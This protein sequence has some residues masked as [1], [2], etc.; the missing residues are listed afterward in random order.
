MA[1]GT[2]LRRLL[3]NPGQELLHFRMLSQGSK[4]IELALK[5]LLAKQSV[6]MVMTRSAH[7]GNAMFDLTP[8]KIS[9]VPLVRMA[10]SRDEMMPCQKAHLTP[11]Q[12][13]DAS[14][15]HLPKA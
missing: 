6:H 1:D 3:A 4:S 12:F 11:A 7:P 14:R 5:R 2:K 9:F 15:F 13:A 8:L 10:R